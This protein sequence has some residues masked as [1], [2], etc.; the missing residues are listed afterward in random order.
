M[1][2]ALTTG[3]L[4][5]TVRG[6][7]LRIRFMNDHLRSDHPTEIVY[8]GV[9][10]WDSMVQREQHLI[11]GL[12]RSYRILFVDPPLS[13][14]TLLLASIRGKRRSFRS[15][16]RHIHE[17]LILYTP[18]AFL[19]FSQYLRSIHGLHRRFLVSSVRDVLGQLS[20]HNYALGIGAPFLGSVVNAF[21]PRLSYY[22]CSD[23]YLGSP[24][25]RGNKEMLGK[26]EAE[27]A[28][29]VD[30]VFCSSKGL[31]EAKSTLNRNCFLVPNGVDLSSFSDGASELETP[32][33]ME[34]IQKPILGYVGLIDERFD[35]EALVRLAET[36]RDWS[37]VMIGP[38][39]SRRFSTILAGHSN[40]H[41]L[42]EKPFR[43][44]PSYLERFDVG[45]IPFKVNAFTE[46]IYP[47]KLHQY[48]GA[49]KPVVSSW[50]P[51]L[52]PFHP[53]VGF[54]RHGK[55]MEEAVERA[56]KEDSEEKARERKKV[57]SENTWDHRV[58]A[59]TDIFDDYFHKN[60]ETATRV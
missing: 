25:L 7:S 14:L 49:G 42:G 2:V 51:D 6:K 22:D 44:L 60:R 57:A 15:R 58:K 3:T 19:P 26:L 11:M 31:L 10:R 21:R 9:N 52:E 55:E 1:T 27:L 20:F 4:T 40:L 33:D 23:D 41:W 18:P 29:S 28:R 48:L 12:S 50:L 35:F 56:L 34:A 32:S 38:L 47:T 8:L 37:I 36:R 59:I 45:L 16:L 39:A 43:A 53:W 5:L 46:K 54:Y 30:L 17:Q 13:F 24:R